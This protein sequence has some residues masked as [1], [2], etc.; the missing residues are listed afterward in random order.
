MTLFNEFMIVFFQRAIALLPLVTVVEKVKG[1]KSNVYSDEN[2]KSV[3]M[4]SIQKTVNVYMY[5]QSLCQFEKR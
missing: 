3:Y 2:M 5:H 4:H 1:C